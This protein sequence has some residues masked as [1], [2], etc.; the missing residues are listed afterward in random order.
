MLKLY[1]IS[2]VG[3]EIG[4]GN[5]NAGITNIV[6]K[7]VIRFHETAIF[8]LFRKARRACATS[9]NITEADEAQNHAFD[10]RAVWGTV[11]VTHAI[12]SI[13]RKV[14]PFP[15]STPSCHVSVVANFGDQLC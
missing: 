14:N 11:S 1:D 7:G 6:H 3:L 2:G 13:D 15:I 5:N 8:N 9:S 4:H 12:A 10:P